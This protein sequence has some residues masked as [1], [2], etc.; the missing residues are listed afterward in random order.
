MRF[1]CHRPFRISHLPLLYFSD[2]MLSKCH[3]DVSFLFHACDAEWTKPAPNIIARA[4]VTHYLAKREPGGWQLH[5]HTCPRGTDSGLPRWV[6]TMPRAP[7]GSARRDV[8]ARRSTAVAFFPCDLASSLKFQCFS[9]RLLVTGF[10]LATFTWRSYQWPAGN[11]G[12]ERPEPVNDHSELRC[13][14]KTT[15]T[16]IWEM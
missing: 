12:P 1:P 9:C 6:G 2:P 7:S 13:Q 15:V 11:W 14:L 8:F 5:K 3:S 10:V 16:N 4:S